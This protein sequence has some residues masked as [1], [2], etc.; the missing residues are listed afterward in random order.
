MDI[1]HV[2]NHSTVKVIESFGDAAAR[3]FYEELKHHR[4]MTT[5][6]RACSTTFFYPRTFC[7]SCHSRGIDWVQVSGKGKLYAFTQQDKAFRFMKPDVVGIV[8]L[9]GCTGRVLTRID[10]PFE[11]L[12]IGMDVEVSFLDLAPDLTLH[13]FRPSTPPEAA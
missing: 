10:A 1:P 2:I 9:E 6:C 7:P 8:E 13:Q 11:D 3:R 12:R 4:F 5:R